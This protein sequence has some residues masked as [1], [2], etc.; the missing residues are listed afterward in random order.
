MNITAPHGNVRPGTLD[1]SNTRPISF[2]TLAKVELRKSY[3]TRAGLWLLIVTAALTV[4]VMAI[5]LIVTAVED[6]SIGFEAFLATTTYSSAFLLPVLGI[7]L[8]TSEWNQRTAM[9]TFTLE[10]HRLRVILA[11]LVAGL[12]LALAVAAIALV[13]AVVMTVLYGLLAS[14]SPSWALDNI[15]LTGFLLA[16]AFAMLTGFAFATLFLN[17]AAAIVVYFAYSFIL[18]GIFEV[19]ANFIGWFADLRPWIDFNDAQ[20]PLLDGSMDGKEW[21]YLIVSGVIWLV[22]PL[23][24]GMW[25]VLRAEVK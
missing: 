13:A 16:Q 12:L 1:F 18:P 17:T 8:V 4:L 23:A 25:R 19:G 24:F 10:P 9:V 2:A 20:T 3:D 7:M 14:D 15:S 11:K 21:A 5:V 6:T 22:I